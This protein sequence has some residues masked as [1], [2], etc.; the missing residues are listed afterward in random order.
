MGSGVLRPHAAQWD[1]RMVDEATR[2]R[3]VLAAGHTDMARWSNSASLDSAWNARA[4]LAAKLI[5]AGSRVLD[6]GCGAMELERHLP[7]TCTYR[8]ADVVARD[9]RTRIVDL[10]AGT[11]AEELFASIDVVVMLGVW[12]YLYRPDETFVAL[13]RAGVTTV[14]SYCVT[15]ITGDVYERRRSGWVNDLSTAEFLALAAS[16]GYHPTVSLQFGVNNTLLKLMKIQR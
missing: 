16:H 3:T 14:C 15:D 13:A 6:L 9:P 4:V 1:Y 11:P 7:P 10:N 8:P 2:R 12:E 5:P